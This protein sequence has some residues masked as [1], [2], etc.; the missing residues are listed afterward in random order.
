MYLSHPKL[1]FADSSEL[2]WNIEK[3]IEIIKKD[4]ENLFGSWLLLCL[5]TN[6]F[7]E[8]DSNIFIKQKD[9]MFFSNNVWD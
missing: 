1:I 8:D 6:N 3:T 5:L 7:S 9:N 2:C 4:K